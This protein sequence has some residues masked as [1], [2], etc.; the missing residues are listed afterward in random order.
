LVVNSQPHSAYRRVPF[1]SIDKLPRQ[2]YIKV[3][4]H[5]L[6]LKTNMAREDEDEKRALEPLIIMIVAGDL[7][8]GCR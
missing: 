1:S 4:T 2:D 6:T 3:P 8:V 5:E 7:F